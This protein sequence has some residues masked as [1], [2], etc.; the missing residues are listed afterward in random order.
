MPRI[1]RLLGAFYAGLFLHWLAWFCL[2][3]WMRYPHYTA[4]IVSYWIPTYTVCLLASY[5]W[6]R[7]GEYWAAV[8]PL[9]ISLVFHRPPFMIWDCF[10]G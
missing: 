4:E 1:N 10:P 9:F 5:W 7:R 3:I 2:P 6:A 8:L